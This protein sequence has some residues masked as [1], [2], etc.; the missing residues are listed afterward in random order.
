MTR[1]TETGSVAAAAEDIPSNANTN[2]L[3]TGIPPDFR[4]NAQPFWLHICALLLDHALA[5][6]PIPACP[7]RRSSFRQTTAD[8][9]SSKKMSMSASGRKR[10]FEINKT[11]TRPALLLNDQGRDT[12]PLY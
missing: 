3:I 5:E 1:G 11:K 7:Q 9:A 8:V 12:A 6:M 4:I 2:I 10:T